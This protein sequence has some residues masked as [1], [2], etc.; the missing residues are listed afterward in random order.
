MMDKVF[1]FA[2]EAVSPTDRDSQEMLKTMITSRTAAYE[3]KGIDIVSD[4]S[5]LH[6]MMASNHDWFLNMTATDGERRY[7]VCRVSEN[8]QGD[9]AFFDALHKQMY[10]QGGLQALMHDLKVTDLGDWTPRNSIPNT[11]AMDDQKI[12][13]LDPVQKWWHEILWEGIMPF[14]T[15][16]EHAPGWHEAPVRVF[17]ETLRDSFASWAKGEGIRS[18]ASNRSIAKVFWNELEKV[19]G[20]L[21]EYRDYVPPSSTVAALPDGR[22]RCVELGT[23]QE[24]RE[25]FRE[26]TQTEGEWP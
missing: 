24:M 8:R 10:E 4:Q 13:N 22:A 19:T 12:Q 9:T 25:R 2:D 1:V 11:R 20:P 6:V 18:G 21:P 17:R 7:M 3:R 5:C 26:N 16:D 14:E 23:L 15:T